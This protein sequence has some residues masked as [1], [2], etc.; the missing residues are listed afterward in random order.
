MNDSYLFNA[1]RGNAIFSLIS[2]ASFLLF[3]NWLATLHGVSLAWPFA[4]LGAVVIGHGLILWFGS[5]RRPVANLLAQYAIIGDIGWVIGTI[6]L[7]L[8]DPWN[9][10][11]QGKIF[12]AI[13][14]DIVALFGILQ[15]SL[16]HI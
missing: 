7:L 3:S 5:N 11:G 16:I 1:I 10:T 4:L 8:I 15:L 6:V 2:G 13:I 9:F 14:A 12:L